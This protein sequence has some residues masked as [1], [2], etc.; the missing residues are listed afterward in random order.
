LNTVPTVEA[1]QVSFA[2]KDRPVLSNLDFQ[3][4]P[5]ELVGITGP[6]G[7]GKTTFIKLILGL[8]TPHSGYVKVF[9]R[10][11][12][13]RKTRLEVRKQ[14]GYLPQISEQGTLPMTVFDSIMLG[15]WGHFAHALYPGKEDFN[16][17]EGIIQRFDLTAWKNYDYRELSGGLRQKVALARALVRQPQ[18]LLLDEPTTYL[19]PSSQQE[20]MELVCSWHR[21]GEMSTIVISHDRQVLDRYVHR[22]VSFSWRGEQ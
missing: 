7:V 1:Y 6:N 13:S 19:D 16:A 2:Y 12:E 10:S 22:V 4:N 14:I 21:L 20:I 11:M 18:L 3:I 9:G 15:R 5:G 8:Y 17:V